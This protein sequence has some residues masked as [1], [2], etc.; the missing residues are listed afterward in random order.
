MPSEHAALQ[1]RACSH[2]CHRD[3]QQT[4]EPGVCHAMNSD[5]DNITLATLIPKNKMRV[6]LKVVINN[7]L[8]ICT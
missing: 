3:G 6:G 7:K 1:A 2:D 8:A 4:A 5:V